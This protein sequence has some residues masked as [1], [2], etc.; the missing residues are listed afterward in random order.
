MP[1][2]SIVIPTCN[3][4][5]YLLPAITAIVK[6]SVDFEIIV[7]DNSD[8]DSI[9]G[10]LASYISSGIVRYQYISSPVS[11]V[12][13][14]ESGVNLAIGDYVICLG[15]DDCIGPGFNEVVA[16]AKKNKID[17]VFSY[18]ERFIANY[19][20]P[21]VNSRYFGSGYQA[22]MFVKPYDGRIR[23]INGLK[24]VKSA[25]KNLGSGLGSMPRIYHG[26]VRREILNLIREKYGSI[27]GGVSPDIYSATL[28]ALETNLIYSIDAPFVIPGASPK[29]TA[30]QGAAH[31][32]RAA[33]F[34][35]DHIK[36]F[37]MDLKWSRLVPAYYGPHNVWA[38]SMLC[39]LDRVAIKSIKPNTMGL[40]VRS[41]ISDRRYMTEIINAARESINYRG[42]VFSLLDFFSS[43]IFLVFSIF[44][45]VYW[46]YCMG[47][48]SYSNLSDIGMAIDE[49]YKHD[50]LSGFKLSKKLD[51]QILK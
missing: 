46:K 28:I 47:T 10:L 15:D 44:R 5:D 17:A 21:G 32:D 24:V 2:V 20:W 13:N 7:S 49:L 19:F 39:A 18:R 31:T 51:G 26:L 35:V 27:F 50:K 48:V 9:R 37:G 11:V 29:S 41:L 30:G 8:T 36:R 43:V 42:W 16:W 45:R 40:V 38:Y 12:E 6:N 1:S 23:K 25:A 14:F 34:D 3:R 4:S 22:K 33:L